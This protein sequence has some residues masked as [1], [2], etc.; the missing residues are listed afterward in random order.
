MQQPTCGNLFR[1][2]FVRLLPPCV[3]D[4]VA[5]DLHDCLLVQ[6]DAQ[7]RRSLEEDGKRGF[8]D[9]GWHWKRASR[10]EK[11]EHGGPP[12]P[13]AQRYMWLLAI[14]A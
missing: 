8:V 7:L 3:D 6:D 13:Q 10:G 12:L 14:E 11:E 1:L 9:G 2:D 5:D 4:A